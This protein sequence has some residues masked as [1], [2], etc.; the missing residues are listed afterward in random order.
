MI[1]RYFFHIVA[2]KLGAYFVGW[3]G[4]RYSR[5][6]FPLAFWQLLPLPSS[7][8]W[9]LVRGRIPAVTAMLAISACLLRI[10]AEER[11]RELVAM[12]AHPNLQNEERNLHFPPNTKCNN[13][14]LT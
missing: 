3:M 13:P 9:M 4:A 11:R 8:R 7:N 2:S 10:C 14:W 5:A 6:S 1:I 12:Q